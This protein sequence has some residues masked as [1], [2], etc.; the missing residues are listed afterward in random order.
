MEL[1]VGEEYFVLTATEH[2]SIHSTY[3]DA[4]PFALGPDGNY[5]CLVS[6]ID[7]GSALYDYLLEADLLNPIFYSKSNKPGGGM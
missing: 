5:Y 1:I 3:G 7:S 4:C 2:E 6:A